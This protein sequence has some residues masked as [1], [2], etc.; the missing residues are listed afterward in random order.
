MV[1]GLRFE[2]NQASEFQMVSNL[3]ASLAWRYRASMITED[4]LRT[5]S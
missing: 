3:C 1:C 5:S 2:E 4:T